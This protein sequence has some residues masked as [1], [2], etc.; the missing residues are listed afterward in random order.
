VQ[1]QV[2]PE[3]KAAIAASV[4]ASNSPIADDK[5]GGFHEEGGVWATGDRRATG[6]GNRGQT[7]RFLGQAT[8]GNRGNR[9][10]TGR[11][12]IFCPML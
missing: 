11:F 10:Q 4:K 8:G 5:K 2:P 3:V 6:D 1:N 12:L 9:G 7:G